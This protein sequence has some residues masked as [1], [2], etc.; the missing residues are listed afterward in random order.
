MRARIVLVVG[1]ALGLLAVAMPV[2]AAA[3]EDRSGDRVPVH[4]W[5]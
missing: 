1:L 3:A 4:A 5:R 2:V